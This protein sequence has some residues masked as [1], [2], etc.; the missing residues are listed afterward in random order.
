M[1]SRLAV[2]GCVSIT[3]WIEGKRLIQA[4]RL[5]AERAR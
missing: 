3:V 1:F 5:S 4:P 2:R